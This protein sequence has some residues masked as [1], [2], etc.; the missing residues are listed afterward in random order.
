VYELGVTVLIERC[1]YSNVFEE[2][3]VLSHCRPEK[4]EICIYHSNNSTESQQDIANVLL[5]ISIFKT[6]SA[7]AVCMT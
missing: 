1:C 3:N 5:Q 2:R 4:K 6:L 7:V